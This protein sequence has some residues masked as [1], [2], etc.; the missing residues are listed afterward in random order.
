MVEDS[1]IT[2]TPERVYYAMGAVV[3]LLSI[4]VVDHQKG[5]ALRVCLKVVLDKR[6]LIPASSGTCLQCTC[7]KR[8]KK[9]T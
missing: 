3:L 4:S 9:I 2:E 5:L 7:K 6:Q 1:F 8:S